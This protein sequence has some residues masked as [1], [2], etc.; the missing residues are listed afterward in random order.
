MKLTLDMIAKD[1][2]EKAL[3]EFIYEGKTIREWVEIL[4]KQQPCDDC[5]SREALKERFRWLEKATKYGNEDAEQQHFSYSTMMM[6]EIKDEIDNVI[7]SL[8]SVQ[9]QNL[10]QI[11]W[12]RDT[13][14]E[15]LK[16]LGYGLGEKIEP[17]VDCV[18]RLDVLAILLN[19][20]NESRFDGYSDY[21]AVSDLVAD[22]PSIKPQ[23]PQ[24]KWIEQNDTSKHH[25]GWYYCSNCG[26]YLMSADGAN[27]CS[28][29]GAEMEGDNE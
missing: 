27:Y 17:C 5:V 2:A 22:L 9:P 12:E 15:Q 14:I 11:K 28:C 23:R 10:E 1:V 21:R 13:A 20:Y 26:A 3:D 16:Q 29:C 8:P 6:Y 25:F 18:N 4:A 19:A 7:D 24:G